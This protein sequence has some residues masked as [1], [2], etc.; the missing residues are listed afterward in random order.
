[1]IALRAR[2]RAR[3]RGQ[4]PEQDQEPEPEREEG[5]ER[6]GNDPT[7]TSQAQGDDFRPPRAEAGY[8]TAKAITAALRELA[9]ADP[10]KDPRGWLA[11]LRVLLGQAETGKVWYDLG[12]DELARW[13]NDLA[14][15]LAALKGTSESTAGRVLN[16]LTVDTLLGRRLPELRYDPVT[17]RRNTRAYSVTE[18]LAVLSADAS[19][20]ARFDGRVQQ[21]RGTMGSDS[22]ASFDGHKEGTS[23]PSNG[24]SGSEGL[25][26]S[27]PSAVPEG[28][29]RYQT[30]QPPT[31][32]GRD[33]WATVSRSGSKP[34]Q[35]VRSA[36]TQVDKRGKPRAGAPSTASGNASRREPASGKPADQQGRVVPPRDDPEAVEKLLKQANAA[37]ITRRGSKLL[38]SEQIQAVQDAG[39]KVP[40]WLA[41]KVPQ[42]RRQLRRT[43]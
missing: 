1:M 5:G 14:A 11:R 2:Q 35:G 28:E 23:Y 6:S 27:S 10:T 8:V 26:P 36:S 41:S 29:G 3:E 37:A 43:A 21:V 7:R 15:A 25:G 34:P 18:A 24:A 20:D 30:E 40:P 22:D 33:R 42:P 9:K 13:L 19:R 31:G 39:L 16:K 32:A 38:P 17:H 12:A 4:A